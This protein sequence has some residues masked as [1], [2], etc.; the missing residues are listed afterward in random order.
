MGAG[1]L[2][3]EPSFVSMGDRELYRRTPT[4]ALGYRPV[5]ARR[6]TV[7]LPAR[8]LGTHC[9]DAEGAKLEDELS[10]AVN[11]L[12]VGPQGLGG[13]ATAFA[14][15]VELAAEGHELEE[16]VVAASSSK[17]TL[18]REMARGNL[19]FFVAGGRRRICAR[20]AAR[21]HPRVF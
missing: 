13:D 18:Y 7:A 5:E 12:G 1:I 16:A 9:A 21:A 4:T 14:V 11:M 6:R 19:R 17:S 20:A 3:V 15:H 10:A 2:G 8:P